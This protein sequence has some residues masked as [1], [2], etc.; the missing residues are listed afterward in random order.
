MEIHAGRF[1]NVIP[2]TAFIG[3][4]ALETVAT[5]KINQQAK[6]FRRG[7]VARKEV[8][9]YG[10]VDDEEHWMGSTAAMGNS[11]CVGHCRI[12]GYWQRSA[13]AERFRNG[14]DGW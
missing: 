1:M 9:G 2:F 14:R 7:N 12:G 6:R 13:R 11:G 3:G 4:V 8:E 10:Y 5:R